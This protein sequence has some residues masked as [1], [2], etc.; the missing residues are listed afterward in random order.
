MTQLEVH[1]RCGC[2]HGDICPTDGG[3]VACTRLQAGCFH[4]GAVSQLADK[5]GAR[6]MPQWSYLYRDDLPEG[7][8]QFNADG[9]V[10][11]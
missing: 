7:G 9:G 6:G 5:V 10:G 3:L 8:C 1:V 4:T 2:A 11:W